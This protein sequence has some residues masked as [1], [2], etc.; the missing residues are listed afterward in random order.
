MNLKGEVVKKN[1]GTHQSVA[2]VVLAFSKAELLKQLVDSLRTQTRKPDEII[3]VFQGSDARI[4]NWLKEQQD[5]T[6]HAQENLGSAGGF[7]TGIQLAIAK[8][9]RWTWIVDDDAVPA[10][11]ALQRMVE[12]P[13]FDWNSTGFLSSRIVDPAGRTYMSPTPKDANLWYGTVLTEHCV[14]VMKAT[15]LGMLVSTSAVIECG[16][17]IKEYF[18]WDE[19]IEFTSRIAHAR[20]SYCV[21]DSVIVHYQKDQFDPFSP[22][23]K[24]KHLHFVRNRVATIRLSQGTFVKRWAR[25]LLWVAKVVGDV[26]KRKAPVESI[27]WVLNGVFMFRPRIQHLELP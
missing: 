15:W 25:I 5:L 8:G 22:G 11:D 13:H 6:L 3:V 23:D 4:L 19:D 2:V 7:S 26:F 12:S 10:A 9:H 16:L 24:I 27:F 20:P 21:I 14:P 17:P 1:E 18:L